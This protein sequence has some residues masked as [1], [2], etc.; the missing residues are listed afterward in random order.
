MNV[1]SI[2]DDRPDIPDWHKEIVRERMADLKNNPQQAIDFDKAMDETD[3]LLN[4]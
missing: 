2:S 4:G 1:Q 3:R